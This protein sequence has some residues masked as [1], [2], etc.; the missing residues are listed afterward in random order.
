MIKLQRFVDASQ[1]YQQASYYLLRQEAM[2]Y[3]LLG[4]SNTL[5]KN[6]EKYNCQPYLATVEV[7]EDII[8]VAIRI[9]PR[10]LLLSQ[11]KN[12][13]AVELIAQDLHSQQESLLG[14]NAPSVESEA[15]A[16]LWTSLTGQSFKLKMA[17]RAWRLEQVQPIATPA[18]YLR[19]VD[20]SDRKLLQNWHQ[21]FALEALGETE[22]DSQSW[23]NYQLRHQTAY[24]WENKEPV[25]LACRS[26]ITPNGVG[27]NTVYTPP[28]HRG[29][30][31]ASACVAKLS[32]YLLKSLRYKYCFLFTDLANSTS[33]HIYQAMGY[34]PVGD[35]REYSFCD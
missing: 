32:Q 8:A 25:S 26:G 27:V 24:L 29:K 21:A 30:G 13:A 14:V 20:K 5:I 4:I 7:E 1:F 9:P 12:L 3:I 18:G 22:P 15:F 11:I 6:P 23:V 16:A 28:Q 34:Q 33:N 2:H 19:V 35:W 31:Y 17:L 10:P